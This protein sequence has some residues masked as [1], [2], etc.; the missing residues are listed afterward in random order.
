VLRREGERVVLAAVHSA[1]DVVRAE[2]FEAIELDL[3]ALGPGAAAL[4]V[5]CDP[6]SA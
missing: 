2:P 3:L 5:A 1:A 6:L 4:V